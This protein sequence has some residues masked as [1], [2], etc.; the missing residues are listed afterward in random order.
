MVG[1]FAEHGLVV[2]V[3]RTKNK[4]KAIIILIHNLYI[5]GIRSYAKKQGDET[6]CGD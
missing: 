5:S 3:V 6:I 4:H 1:L 2:L